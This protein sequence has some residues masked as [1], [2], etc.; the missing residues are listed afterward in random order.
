MPHQPGGQV[1]ARIPSLSEATLKWL[2]QYQKGRFE[3]TIDTSQLSQEVTKLTR[4][5]RELVI[6][7]ILV[8]IIIGS[9]V[10]SYG[11]AAAGPKG[12][13][14]DL[15]SRLVPIML[16]LALL[17]AFFIVLRLTWRWLRGAAA[18]ED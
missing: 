1:I 13:M 12:Q 14:W 4:L 17:V 10:G 3:I 16:I 2:D 11:I 5:G 9:A 8:G 15:L 6:A 18:D 7:I